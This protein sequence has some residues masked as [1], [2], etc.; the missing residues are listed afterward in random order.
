MTRLIKKERN[1]NA[2]VVCI[3]GVV[4]ILNRVVECDDV[5]RLEIDGD[6]RGAPLITGA[7]AEL[8]FTGL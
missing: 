7:T 3:I 1:T 6:V 5:V 2:V 8:P 4:K